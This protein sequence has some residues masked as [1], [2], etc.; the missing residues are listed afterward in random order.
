MNRDELY[1]T[2]CLELAA[3]G[4]GF[5]APNPL[6]GAVLVHDDIII[7]SGYHTQLGAPH[8]EVNAINAVQLE[9]AH[10]ISASTLY[11]NLEPCN[12][13][14]KTPPCTELIIAQS[15]KK[16]VIGTLDP[17]PIVAGKGIEKLKENGVEV[18][19]GIL[20][21][22]CRELN[23]FFFTFHE[24]KRPF[25]T[26]KWAQSADGFIAAEGHVPVHFTNAICDKLVQDLR[27]EHSTIFVG[28][29]TI[30]SD[31]PKLTN[32]SGE[33]KNPLR[34]TLD[35]KNNFPENLNILNIDAD[36]IIFN[37]QKNE[38]QNN[39]N[40]L[41]L[42]PDE[43]WYAQIIKILFSKNINSILVE[44]GAKTINAL[45]HLYLWDSMHIFTSDHILHKGIRAPELA[46]IEISSKHIENNTLS[47]RI[48]A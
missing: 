30:I 28:G 34:I 3:L 12:H 37:L 22:E 25:I 42:Q 45:M 43:N 36:T 15:I 5:V 47:I 13:F 10:L 20:E 33:G 27:A 23:K 35:T 4:K 16:V 7:G 40:Y 11:V 21:K 9:N 18:I 46:G 31:N 6:V 29:R 38:I 32:R 39:I 26:L 17:N 19:V 44:G 8:A 48:N 14:G 1:I 2:R 24:K 41:K